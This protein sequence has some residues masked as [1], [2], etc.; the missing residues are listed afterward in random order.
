M[1]IFGG[2]ARDRA[3]RLRKRIVTIGR[4]LMAVSLR[5]GPPAEALGRGLREQGL[6]GRFCLDVPTA[7]YDTGGQAANGGAVGSIP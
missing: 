7:G 4:E 2:N 5:V 1:T 6:R 3:Q